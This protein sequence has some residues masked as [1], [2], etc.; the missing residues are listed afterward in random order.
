[1]EGA[2]DVSIIHH[3]LEGHFGGEI[4]PNIAI[5]EIDSVDVPPE[6]E[7]INGVYRSGKKSQVVALALE[8]SKVIPSDSHSITCIADLDLDPLMARGYDS[9]FLLSTDYTSIDMY[10]LL[11]QATISKYLKIN[12]NARRI[13]AKGMMES[14]ENILKYLYVIRGAK[15]S[16]NLRKVS[17]KKFLKLQKGR[18]VFDRSGYVRALT[19]GKLEDVTAFEEEVSRVLILN[20]TAV[21][22]WSHHEDFDELFSWYLLELDYKKPT[23]EKRAVFSCKDFTELLDEPLFSNLVSRLTT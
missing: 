17:V 5:F 18:P 9:P 23:Y 12:H 1:M 21:P 15:E 14:F 10:F 20:P 13:N 8:L 16:E 4:P 3:A 11:D 2:S 6:I 7:Y 22:N 19:G